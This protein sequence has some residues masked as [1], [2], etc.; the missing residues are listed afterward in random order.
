MTRHASQELSIPQQNAGN[1]C[2]YSVINHKV[3]QQLNSHDGVQSL[4]FCPE[5]TNNISVSTDSLSHVAVNNEA[6]QILLQQ[7]SMPETA[8]TYM[9]SEPYLVTKSFLI[10]E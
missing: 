9:Y 8:Q 1:I 10:T 4:I 7:H 5:M 6:W 2:N 3:F